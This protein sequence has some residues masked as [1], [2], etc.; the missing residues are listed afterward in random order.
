MSKENTLNPYEQLANAIVLQAVRDYRTAL[1]R[2]SKN[3]RSKDALAVK[4]ECE[5]FFRSSWYENLT[6]VDAEYLIRKLN[7]E[8]Y[9]DI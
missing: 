2:L 8:V 3:P 9:Y 5:R 7:E 6:S 4:D 1:K